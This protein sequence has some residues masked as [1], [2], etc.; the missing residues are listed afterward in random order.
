[1]Q[2]HTVAMPAFLMDENPANKQ[3]FQARDLFNLFPYLQQNG[4]GVFSIRESLQA[5]SRCRD[6]TL[7]GFFLSQAQAWESIRMMNA[8]G[9][10]VVELPAYPMNRPGQEQNQ[11]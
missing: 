7:Q 9:V 6:G 11:C 4:F 3:F 1:M 8:L 2:T 10:G 5:V